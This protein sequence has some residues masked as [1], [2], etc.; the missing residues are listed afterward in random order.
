TLQRSPHGR[1]RFPHQHD[2]DALDQQD[3]DQ[4]GVDESRRRGQELDEQ[5]REQGTDAGSDTGCDRVRE[6]TARAVDVEHGGTDGA[7]GGA[8][9]DSLYGSGGQQRGYAVGEDED[10]QRDHLDRDRD[11]Q[12]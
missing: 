1:D 5:R 10:D 9:R 3:D 8:G 2:P 6:R 11:K 4:D 12:D 7:G